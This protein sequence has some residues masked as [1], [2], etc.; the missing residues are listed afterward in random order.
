[1][2]E[3]SQL[4]N[5]GIIIVDDEEGIR[6]FLSQELIR[7][8]YK[9]VYRAKDGLECIDILQ[10]KGDGIALVV[11][12]IVMPGLDGIETF[13]HLT[14]VY[15]G[16]VGVIFFTAYS[17]YNTKDLKSDRILNLAHLQKPLNMDT[18]DDT[19]KKT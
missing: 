8:G 15:S 3:D 13:K 17:D 1:M 6:E 5:Q 11:L 10:E 2:P 12:D 18:I 19:L 4:L 7:L 14:N 9:K 16:I